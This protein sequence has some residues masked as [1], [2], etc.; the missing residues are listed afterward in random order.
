[1]TD[2]KVCID[3]GKPFDPI[4]QMENKDGDLSPV[5]VCGECI[6]LLKKRFWN[7]MK[8]E[9]KKSTSSNVPIPEEQGGE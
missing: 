9:I 8:M 2:K 7:S 3:C 5:V 1:M 6:M 4:N